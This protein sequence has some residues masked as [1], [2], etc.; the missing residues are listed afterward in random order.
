MPTAGDSKS[1]VWQGPNM[2]MTFLEHVNVTFTAIRRWILVQF[3]DAV[4]VGILWLAGLWLLDVPFAP[5]WAFLGFIFQFIPH[6]GAILSLIGPAASAAIAGGWTQMSYVLM[7]YAGIVMIDGFVLQ[8]LLMKR[9]ARVPV[10]AS[11]LTPILLA[12]LFNVWG[13]FLA[14][15]LL[16]VIYAY[17]EKKNIE[18]ADG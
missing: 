13:L 2:K 16:A 5:L 6:L 3:Q 18:K 7:L 9:S 8:P 10:W 11:I 17:R 4:L 15:L 12:L 14:P 1:P